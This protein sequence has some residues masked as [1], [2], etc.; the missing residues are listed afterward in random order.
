MSRP[1]TLN[2]TRQAG[3]YTQLG[4][5]TVRSA[6]RDGMTFTAASGDRHMA[7]HRTKLI[8]QSRDFYRNN[9]IYKGMIDRAVAYI[10]GKGFGLQM[11]LADAQ[12]NEIIEKQLWKPFWR[13][14]EIRNLQSGKMLEK[15]VCREAML[16]GDVGLIKTNKSV[17]QVREAEQICG[18]ETCP[19]GVL[20]NQYGT[21]AAF[22]VSQYSEHGRI[23]R[24]TA[25]RIAAEDFLFIANLDRP[26]A[27]RGVPAA[28]SSFPMLHRINDVCDSEAICWQI[29]SK[30]AVSIVREGGPEDGYTRTGPDPDA[31]GKD[32]DFTTRLTELDYALMFHGNPGESVA[33]IDRNIPGRDFPES[34]RMFLRLLGL[35]LGLPLELVLL[36]WT[37]SNY[38]QSRAVLEQAYQTFLDWQDLLEDFFY[39]PILTWKLDQWAAAGLIDGPEAWDFE[40]IRPTFPWIDQLKETQAKGDMV[41]RAFATHGQVCKSLGTDRETMVSA[42]RREVTEAIQVAQEIKQTTGV[43]VPWELFA[44]LGT[45]NQSATPAEKQPDDDN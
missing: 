35:P 18:K 10:V 27:S 19:S 45:A 20:L 39:T 12:A 25:R 28:Q 17:L 30:L 36:D 38:S 31:S 26:S 11:K 37:K 9:A 8:T 43:D 42:R 32:T 3:K 41:D 14:P 13:R 23:D 4:Y 22:F 16:C 29:L 15:M 33:G 1:V 34:I 5:R 2:R 6:E 21:P 44:G 40:W 24:R 7:A